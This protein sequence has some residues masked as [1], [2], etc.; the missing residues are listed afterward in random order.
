MK[1]VHLQSLSDPG[2]LGRVARVVLQA[3][4]QPHVWL[5]GARVVD[6]GRLSPLAGDFVL[7]DDP[8]AFVGRLNKL[9]MSMMMAGG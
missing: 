4:H 9:M 8:A 5:D 1:Q 7:L 6:A 3:G 2:E